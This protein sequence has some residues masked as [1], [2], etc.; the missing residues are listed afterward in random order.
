MRAR[1]EQL[2]AVLR[3]CASEAESRRGIARLSFRQLEKDLGE[4]RPEDA[5]KLRRLARENLQLVRAI[6]R[7][8]HDNSQLRK[9]L[10]TKPNSEDGGRARP[11]R[12]I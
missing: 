11:K 3:E 6:A 4:M 2:L 9:G 5:R 10:G 8:T 1:D 12:L 7:L